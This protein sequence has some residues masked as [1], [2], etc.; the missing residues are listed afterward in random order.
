MSLN[1]NAGG[2]AEVV[3]G[4]VVSGNYYSALG[5]PAL[6]GRTITEADDNAGVTPVAV[7]AIVFGQIG[8]GGDPSVIGKQ[9][10][11]NNVAFTIAGVT[12]PG[13]SGTSEVGSSQDVSIPVAWEPQIAGEQTNMEGAGI[14]W[15]R[16]MGRLQPRGHH[17][18]SRSSSRWAIPTIGARTSRRCDRRDRRLRFDTV[19]PKDLPRLGVDSGSQG[20]MDSRRRF[21]DSLCVCWWE[22]SASCC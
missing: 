20:E 2:Q 14:W 9:V 7:L 15:L 6:V 10:N 18:A 8:F 3:N 12:P 19:D 22:S 11:I 13:F 4:Q 1:L 21:R 5:V 16:L 17:G